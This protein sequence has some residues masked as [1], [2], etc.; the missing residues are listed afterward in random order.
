MLNKLI[1]NLEIF[2]GLLKSSRNVNSISMK[3]GPFNL[4]NQSLSLFVPKK[5]NYFS[6]Y[7]DMFYAKGSGTMTAINYDSRL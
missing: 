3:Y 6:N 1:K 7:H 2:I 5:N 4:G